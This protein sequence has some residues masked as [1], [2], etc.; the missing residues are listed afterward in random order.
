MKKKRR[1]NQLEGTNNQIV[2]L[3]Q[4]ACPTF[5]EAEQLF[6]SEEKS[7]NRL[8]RTIAWHRE[9]LH[10]FKKAL[11]EQNI[12][13]DLEKINYRTI[14][15]NFILYAIEKWDN[16][17]QTINMRIRTLR[18]FFRFLIQEGYLAE[19]PV[20]RVNKLK[21][22]EVLV[23]SMT[24]GQ[25]IKI[26]STSNR[27]TFTG[28]RDF[29]V[30]ILLL[31]TGLRLSEISHLKISDINF[32]ERLIKV[33]GK[34]ARERVVPFQRKCKK[35]LKEYLHYRGTE[36]DHDYLF[37]TIDNEPI[38]NRSIQ[39]RFEILTHKAG[40][41]GIKTSP[42]IWR[43]TFARL[44]ILNGGDPFSL[45]KILGHNSWEMVHR[46]VDLF[47]SQITSQH[48]KA[49]PVENFEDF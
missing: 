43:H 33:M 23:V 40:L 6:Y 19:N 44:Y 27:K 29:T 24:R 41:T 37:V 47:G 25:V 5:E 8:K 48:Q 4:E 38:K 15:N 3:D 49:S 34:G 11:K 39:E 30:M 9:N 17:P 14:K 7:K 46:Y 28:L 31:D 22:E 1:N 20:A 21:T 35:Q 12:E 42:H 2:K 13:P 18:Q 45:K 16:K 26:M 32:K 10:A 36:L